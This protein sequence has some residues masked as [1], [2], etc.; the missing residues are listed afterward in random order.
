VLRRFVGVARFAPFTGVLRKE[1]R[2]GRWMRDIRVRLEEGRER[3]GRLHPVLPD[4]SP[5][6]DF[7][8]YTGNPSRYY[9]KVGRV[10][11]HSF[12]GIPFAN[13]IATD[14]TARRSDLLIDIAKTSVAK[15]HTV[16]ERF[17]PPFLWVPLEARPRA[18]GLTLAFST[19]A[20]RGE[21]G[22]IELVGAP[23]THELRVPFRSLLSPPKPPLDDP[24]YSSEDATRSGVALWI[25]PEVLPPGLRGARLRTFGHR[26]VGHPHSDSGIDEVFEQLEGPPLVPRGEP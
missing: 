19:Y 22:W 15:R 14:P 21:V 17:A 2:L 9:S 23:G 12:S 7:R 13:P 10:R 6:T 16:N 5:W 24:L 26:V 25:A 8:I 20:W 11:R 3:Y 1:G 18:A 4:G